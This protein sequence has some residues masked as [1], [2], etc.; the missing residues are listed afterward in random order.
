MNTSK[1]LF[2][3]FFFVFL[4]ILLLV[5]TLVLFQ[6][7]NTPFV[8]TNVAEIQPTSQENQTLTVTEAQLPTEISAYPAPETIVPPSPAES[9]GYPGPGTV[10]PQ[11]TP[12]PTLNLTPQPPPLAIPKPITHSI[13]ST[14]NWFLYENAE[15]GIS[16]KYP[17][18]PPRVGAQPGGDDLPPYYHMSITIRTGPT[19]PASYA[20]IAS[21]EFSIH[22]N[23]EDL[24]IVDFFDRVKNYYG[25]SAS[26]ANRTP[27][28]DP[29]L[30]NLMQGGAEDAKAFR[31]PG[32]K[33]FHMVK[34]H[35][36]IYLIF[37]GA[38]TE[39]EAQTKVFELLT[40]TITFIETP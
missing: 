29:V 8:G 24:S 39:S 22:T 10:G 33:I 9:G 16:F 36:F 34:S 12:L 3:R 26:V 40:T 19:L 18:F 23:P 28:T 25:G 7:R 1:S 15:L 5:A 4:L 6:F 38:M 2:S 17:E 27:E 32:G 35:G 30:H 21:I 20:N 31:M 11:P 13:E 37:T 14:E